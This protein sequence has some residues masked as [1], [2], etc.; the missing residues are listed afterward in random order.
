MK[1]QTV[2]R[3]LFFSY[4]IPILITIFS[5]SIMFFSYTSR[6]LKQG[7]KENLA[8]ITDKM[9]SIIDGEISKMN[10]LSLNI[11]GSKLLKDNLGEYLE[12]K[13][14]GYSSESREIYLKARDISNMLSMISGPIKTVPQINYI[15]PDLQLVGSGI[16]NLINKIPEGTLSSI[17]N[18]DKEFGKRYFSGPSR[19][20]LAEKAFPL[21]TNQRYI[22][23]YRTIFHEN[24]RLPVGIIEVK[25]FAETI[26]YGFSKTPQNFL[27]FDQELKQLFPY[28]TD[29]LATYT[30]V[31]KRNKDQQ[32]VNFK[33]PETGSRE[34][35]SIGRC[36][37]VN[38]IIMNVVKES[39]ILTPV[40]RFLVIIIISGMVILGIGIAVARK[41]S[42]LITGSLLELSGW[43]SSLHWDSISSD[44][45]KEPQILSPLSEFENIHQAFWRMNRQLGDSMKQVIRE[46]SLQENARMLALQ[47]QMDPHFMY[48]MLTT[49]SIMAEDGESDNIVETISH[50]TKMLRYT[51]SRSRLNVPLAE[52]AEVSLRYLTCMKIRYGDDLKFSIELENKL[53]NLLIPKLIILPLVENSIKYATCGPPPWFIKVSGIIETGRW[54]LRI[55]DSGPGFSDEA[56]ENIRSSMK[57]CA[58]DVNKQL[59]LHI[60]GLGIINI[61]S[62]L[63]IYF[64]D[65][66][67]FRIFNSKNGGAVIEIGG[68][69]EQS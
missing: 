19:D 65:Q 1:K 23:L 14:Y 61:Y 51:A 38:W 53:E 8:D 28:K 36:K 39:E 30:E 22:S 66:L 18:V 24:S 69:L 54:Q 2:R 59:A 40:Y 63:K 5:L 21:Y 17:D 37:E 56:L 29:N 52:E 15:D 46:R 10:T 60:E 35:L 34:I 57:C 43:I 31:L 62:R 33:D 47:S 67:D 32:I 16:Y 45:A 68:R 25:Q 50:M 64:K 6:I 26:F 3:T 27:I 42:G 58:Q 12:L 4:F 13:D 49:I 11:T 20:G 9:V 41:L 55:E 7:E 44:T 48:N